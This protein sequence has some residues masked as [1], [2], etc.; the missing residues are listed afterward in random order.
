MDKTIYGENI[1]ITIRDDAKEL[2][3]FLNAQSYENAV[4]IKSELMEYNPIT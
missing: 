3:I 4:I 2:G 1:I